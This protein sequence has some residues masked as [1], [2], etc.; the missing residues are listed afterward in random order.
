M[1]MQITGAA[2]LD[3]ALKQLA[4][5]TTKGTAKAAMKRGLTDAAQV[6]A[7]AA[8]SMAP[9][10]TGRLRE[11]IVVSTQ[12]V[13]E[14]GKEQYG[15]V[16]SG[17]GTQAQAVKALRDARREASGGGSRITVYV[18]STERRYSHMVEY[19]TVSAPPHPFMRPAFDST[20]EQ[21]AG[22]VT[23]SVGKAVN[24]AAQRAAKRKAKRAAK[25]I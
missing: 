12:L 1:K 13:N 5:D 23:E 22:R 10:V 6:M 24:A 16:L 25:G 17:G 2:E 4:E 8:R 9:V 11:S 15:A 7:E 3:A 18:G 20:V 21:V 14:I 19:G